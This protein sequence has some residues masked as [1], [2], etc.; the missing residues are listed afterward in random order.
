MCAS[1]LSNITPAGIE[2]LLEKTRKWVGR[3]DKGA[4][5]TCLNCAF[6]NQ[7]SVQ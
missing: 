7:C 4:K 3:G 5:A 1:S 6:K 2:I